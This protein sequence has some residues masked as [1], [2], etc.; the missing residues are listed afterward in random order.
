[1]GGR[2]SGAVG[3]TG[4][5]GSEAY[6]AG[7]GRDGERT[8]GRGRCKGRDDEW[9]IG[10]AKMRE[11]RRDQ[12]RVGAR[13]ARMG[14][15]LGQKAEGSLRGSRQDGRAGRGTGKHGAAR[16]SG[17]TNESCAWAQ[18]SMASRM[19]KGKRCRGMWNGGRVEM[20]V[21]DMDRRQSKALGDG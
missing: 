17:Q 7:S 3:A 18:F 20:Q 2:E 6:S 4:Q 10:S 19:S 8:D 5:K 15:R 14:G 1:M 21:G 16:Q 12:S 11:R 13:R 9:H